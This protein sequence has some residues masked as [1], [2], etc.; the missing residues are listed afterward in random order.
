MVRD[1]AFPRQK[2]GKVSPPRTADGIHPMGPYGTL[3]DDIGQA[4]RRWDSQRKSE[5]L[6]VCILLKAAEGSLA[7]CCEES[8]LQHQRQ[9]NQRSENRPPYDVLANAGHCIW[10]WQAFAESSTAFAC[11]SPEFQQHRSIVLSSIV[12]CPQLQSPI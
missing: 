8:L 1:E 12:R 11:H 9:T 5:A 7:G 2:S 10:G 4:T 3:W 6:L